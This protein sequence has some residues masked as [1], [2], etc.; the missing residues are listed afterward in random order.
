MNKLLIVMLTIFISCS[1]QTKQKNKAIVKY[2]ST[3]IHDE[4]CDNYTITKATTVDF[5]YANARYRNLILNDTL[6]YGKQNGIIKLPLKNKQQ[7]VFTDTLQGTDD[8]NVREYKYEGQYKNVGY[9]F[10]SGLFWEFVEGNLVNKSTGAKTAIWTEPII[11]PNGKRIA[12]LPMPY[13]L[14]GTPNG[15][16]IWQVIGDANTTS[17]SSLKKCIEFDQAIWTPIDLAWETDNSFILKVVD[18]D[19]YLTNEG[20]PNTKDAYC[21]RVKL[22]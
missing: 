2:S 18:I 22:R 19:K 21:L 7:V 17:N 13:G 8:T 9:Y 1:Q 16:Q 12:S 3:F 6:V 11:S 14:E 15:F 4:P 10:V 5:T 20:V